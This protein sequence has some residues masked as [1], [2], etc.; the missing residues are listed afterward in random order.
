MIDRVGPGQPI[1]GAV[2][3]RNPTPVGQD[4]TG[5]RGEAQ[6]GSRRRSPCDDQP[7]RQERQREGHA[8]GHHQPRQR[9]PAPGLPGTS[10]GRRPPRGPRR[11]GQGRGSRAGDRRC[12]PP[13]GTGSPPGR[14][15]RAPPRPRPPRRQSPSA[16][17]DKGAPRCPAQA[18]RVSRRGQ[19]ERGARSAR[20]IGRPVHHL[21]LP[22]SPR[23]SRKASTRMQDST[24]ARV[25]L[26]RP[27]QEALDRDQAR[28]MRADVQRVLA[29]DPVG[30]LGQEPPGV[31]Y[32]LPPWR[33]GNSR[34]RPRSNSHK[35]TWSGRTRRGSRR[36]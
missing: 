36:G 10:A 29:A 13:A 30:I 1:P 19:V 35:P 28:R 7:D 21:E 2:S 14:A 17:A 16:P 27:Q 6:R 3:A 12:R 23:P 22:E 5:L 9:P 8:E 32:G 18:S 20:G 4:Q 15:A 31:G 25:S 34:S 26:H 11:Q 24:A 33:P